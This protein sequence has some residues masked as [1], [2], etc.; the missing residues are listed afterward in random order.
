[1]VSF[2]F[3]NPCDIKSSTKKMQTCKPDSVNAK[4]ISAS[5]YHLSRSRITAGL[6]LSTLQQR[7]RSP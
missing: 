4:F 2:R 6:K 3:Y 5:P 1:M 7:A